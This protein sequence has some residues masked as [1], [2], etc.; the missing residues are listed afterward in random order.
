MT[1]EGRNRWVAGWW[2]LLLQRERNGAV[3]IK[4]G[5]YPKFNGGVGLDHLDLDGWVS[6][7]HGVGAG[8]SSLANAATSLLLTT[9]VTPAVAAS[10][11]PVVG[12]TALSVPR[13][14][15]K[16]RKGKNK[17]E[18]RLLIPLGPVPP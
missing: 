8:V 3:E 12:G 1:E 6:G 10:V 4:E 17:R 14:P 7:T 5:R 16:N 9:A 13:S 11:S 18:E 15:I 2:L